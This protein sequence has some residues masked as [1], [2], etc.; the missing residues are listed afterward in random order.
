MTGVQAEYDIVI[1]GGRP[2]GA[3][4]AARLGAAGHRV[5]LVDRATFPSPP[6]VPSSP[7]LYP[8]AMAVLDELGIPEADY[9]AALAPVSAFC[10]AFDRH[11]DTVFEVPTM[12]GRK[13]VCGLD[14]VV[15]DEVLWRNVGRFPSVERRAG[16][17]MTG[18]V[19]DESG[20]VVGI[21][22]SGRGGERQEIR[23]R[24]VVGADG[25]FSSVARKAGA[26]VV[27]EETRCLS[28][29]YFAEW[30]GVGRFRDG[31]ESAHAHVTGRGLDV[32]CLP[33]P[34]G[35]M[36]I[37]THARADRV[38]IGGD[39]QR[40][41]MDTIRGVPSVARLLGDARQVTAVVG[42]KR[43]GN[44]Y[45]QA[46][47]P[48][49]AL[50]GDAVHYKDPADGQGIYDALLGARLLAEALGSWLAGE[51]TWEAAMAE[52]EQELHAATGPMFR[53]TVSRLRRELYQEP[54]ALVI[55]TMIRWTMTDPAYQARFMNYLGRAISPT[56]WSSPRLV[57]GAVL[58]GIWR[59]LTGGRAR[60][61]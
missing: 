17:A 56:G 30:E 51:R 46:S 7:I 9:Q 42:V 3:T 57:A 32:L 33:L 1:V 5:L 27:E 53:E 61:A 45:R 44:G 25:R 38:D 10:L 14:R 31:L 52:Y 11:F 28:T 19:R 8:S 20:R 24:A 37:N 29:A 55:K 23:A 6:Q 12:W 36:T 50:V 35:R 59:D 43:I 39:A 4:L 15:F 60:A 54:P 21:V 22:G 40:Y 2:A 34:G 18:L 41:Y 58:R 49:W 47:G 48:G 16:F 13:Y 26:R